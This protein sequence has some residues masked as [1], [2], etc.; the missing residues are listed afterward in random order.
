MLT[1]VFTLVVKT[2]SR[3]ALWHAYL[4]ILGTFVRAQCRH[5]GSSRSARG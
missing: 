5:S 3:S 2:S 4:K 1:F